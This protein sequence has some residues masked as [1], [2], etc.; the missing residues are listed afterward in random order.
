MFERG[1]D[2]TRNRK[3]STGI[4]VL[5]MLAGTLMPAVQAQPARRVKNIN[6]T[7]TAADAFPRYRGVR[8]TE[9][10]NL[11][12]VVYFRAVDGINVTGGFRSPGEPWRSDGTEAGTRLVSDVTPGPNGEVSYPT[13]VGKRL[14]FI[15]TGNKLWTSDGTAEGTVMLTDAVPGND[16][17]AGY[18]FPLG[19]VNDTLYTL[20]RG[21]VGAQYHFF[22][23]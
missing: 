4:I 22:R 15:A 13:A 16:G 18:L 19:A 3:A 17:Y 2:P 12:G 1:S 7:S 8:P 20:V 14:F 5:A 11:D 10:A 6:P 9:F 23:L 21:P